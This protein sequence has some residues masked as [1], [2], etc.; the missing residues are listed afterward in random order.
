[1]NTDLLALKV[2]VDNEGMVWYIN[3]DG[4]PIC[5]N[6]PVVGFLLTKLCNNPRIRVIGLPQN[7]HLILALY[8]NRLKNN[9]G[10]VE[11]CSPLVCNTHAERYNPERALLAMRL[12]DRTTSMGG[13]HVVK[14]EEQPA[15]AL[16]CYLQKYNKVDDYA[17]RLLK[18]HAVW[19]ALSFIPHINIDAC[20]E[21]IAL[22]LDPRWY[23]DFVHPGRGSKLRK[24][25]GLDLKTLIGVCKQGTRQRQHDRCKLVLDSWSGE[26]DLSQIEQPNYFLF[27]IF[28]DRSSKGP[29]IG[30]LRTS[31]AFIEYLRLTWLAAIGV[32]NNQSELL[33]V[34][35]H[36]FNLPYEVQAFMSHVTPQVE[37]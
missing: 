1:M 12:Y 23:I 22:I 27:R 37:N 5:S 32:N 10:I 9:K 11:V 6:L 26:K 2:Y 3:S 25:L 17:R 30:T 34:P 20:C 24:F 36:F 4:P 15:Y 35:H 14:Q 13:W 8:M 28:R 19:P 21:L 31:Q 7:V 18:A 16:A 29:F 33:F